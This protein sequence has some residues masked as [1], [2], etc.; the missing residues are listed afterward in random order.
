[1]QIGGIQH[2]LLLV[3]SLPPLP[4]TWDAQDE[5]RG[6]LA[7]VTTTVAKPKTERKKGPPPQRIS[8]PVNALVRIAACVGWALLQWSRELRGG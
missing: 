4:S 3:P 6:G 5:P 7:A 8:F 1:M 2:P